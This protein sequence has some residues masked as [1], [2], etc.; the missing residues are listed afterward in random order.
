MIDSLDF[1]KQRINVTQGDIVYS[2]S[3]DEQTALISQIKSQESELIFPRSIIHES[4]EYIITG[5]FRQVLDKYSQ[6]K[7]IKFS[8]NS[9][10]Q[11]F[12][13]LSFDRSSIE[14]I[15]IPSSTTIIGNMAFCDCEK[16]QQIEFPS[17]SKL[18]KIGEFAFSGTMVKK[19]TIPINLIEIDN[20]AFK[21]CKQL[22]CVEIPTDSKIQIIVKT[23]FVAHQLKS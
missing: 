22:Q 5:T 8:K 21:S 10:L 18:K 19:L 4:K 15:T 1:E 6:V 12:G 9:E 20:Y 17:D 3:E 13:Y 16:L 11:F 23:H 2:I 14:S 7:F